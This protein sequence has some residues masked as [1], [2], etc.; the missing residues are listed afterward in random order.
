MFS[1]SEQ[2]SESISQSA[3]QSVSQLG[4]LSPCELSAAPC[5]AHFTLHCLLL[6]LRFDQS[7]Q[8]FNN[9]VTVYLHIH[10]YILHN[11]KGCLIFHLNKYL[12]SRH[13]HDFPIIIAYHDYR[14]IFCWS[15]W[16]ALAT[17]NKPQQHFIQDV[18]WMA[19]LDHWHMPIYS[20][21]EVVR[22]RSHQV[23]ALL[24]AP[25]TSGQVW[26]I[27]NTER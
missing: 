12:G 15:H 14:N 8:K 24:W 7:W 16:S 23:V 18:C 3:N 22:Q 27:D 5:D 9:S 6:L 26:L 1:P 17:I 10:T 21:C 25:V 19:Q 4:I 20:Q 11:N 2:V 13:V